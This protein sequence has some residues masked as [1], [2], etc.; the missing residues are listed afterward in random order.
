MQRKLVMP[1]PCL[2]C[3]FRKDVLGGGKFIRGARARQIAEELRRGWS[4]SCHRT[5]HHDDDGDPIDR[6][7]ELHCAG[8]AIVLERDGTPNQL[9]QLAQ[10]LGCWKP[11][12]DPQQVVVASL[13]DF[14]AHHSE[15]KA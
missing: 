13:D 14:V 15:R 7:G 10:R 4:F 8:A 6:E 9:M 3:P 2:H 5:V 11:P 1:K 12:T